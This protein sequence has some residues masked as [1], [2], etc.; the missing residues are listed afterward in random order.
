MYR[1]GWAGGKGGKPYVAGDRCLTPGALAALVFS[2]VRWQEPHPG[3]GV[4]FR[5]NVQ[6]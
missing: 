6:C 3:W 4:D 5:G 2:P 1:P